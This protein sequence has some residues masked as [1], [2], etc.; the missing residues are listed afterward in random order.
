MFKLFTRRWFASWLLWGA[1]CC[2]P[3]M[4][5]TA[6]EPIRFILNRTGEEVTLPA[7]MGHPNSGQAVQLPTGPSLSAAQQLALRQAL[8]LHQAGNPQATETRL[9]ALAEQTPA[10][11]A[12]HALLGTFYQGQQQ[13]TL[14]LKAFTQAWQISPLPSYLDHMALMQFMLGQKTHQWNG[15]QHHTQQ[16]PQHAYGWQLLGSAYLQQGQPTQGAQAL[17][18]ATTL[19]PNNPAIAFNL[20]CALEGA[21]QL[22]QARTAYLNTLKL[23]PSAT[24]AL[25]ALSRVEGA[26]QQRAHAHA[27]QVLQQLQQT[28]PAQPVANHAIS[29]GPVAMPMLAVPKQLTP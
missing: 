9:K 14:A 24:D 21:G 2:M 25:T 6:A 7:S 29:P 13:Y 15:L 19:N 10:A 27:Q 16:H 8:I 17:Q 4:V 11:D 5:A 3:A 28:T 22:T 26:Q 23:Q 20:G 12:M 18:Q 1:V